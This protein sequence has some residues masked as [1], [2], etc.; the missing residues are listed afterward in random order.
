M[1]ELS[2]EQISHSL[3]EHPIRELETVRRKPK[4]V[5][6]HVESMPLR[7]QE[8]KEKEGEWTRCLWYY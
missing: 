8:V 4:L 1:W 7:L 6:K 2:E 5:P 3:F